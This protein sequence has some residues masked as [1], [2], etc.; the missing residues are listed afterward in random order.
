MHRIWRGAGLIAFALLG[1]ANPVAS[2]FALGVKAGTVGVG[3]DFSFGVTP[4]IALRLGASTIPIK[5]EGTYSDVTYRVEADGPLLTAH[6]DLYL[7]RNLRLMGGVFVVPNET[8]ITA[9]YDGTVNI[10][11]QSYSGA[12]LGELLGQVTSRSLSPFV[13]IGLGKTVGSRI[14]LALDIGAAF[15][16]EPTLALGANGPCTQIEQCNQQLQAN[17]GREAAEILDEF[18]RYAKIIP[19]INLGLHFGFGAR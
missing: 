8:T 13:G 4:R 6:A 7:L 1:N 15:T 16:G 3:G 12:D 18:D 9:I 19:V 5:P 14:A 11:G 10:G 2:Q 17:L